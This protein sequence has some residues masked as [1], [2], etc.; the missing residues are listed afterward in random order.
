MKCSPISL[1]RSLLLIGLA[2][3]PLLA[4]AAL[5]STDPD[6]EWRRVDE[7]GRSVFHMGPV[8][9]STLENRMLARAARVTEADAAYLAFFE[10]YPEDPHRWEAALRYINS[11]EHFTIALKPAYQDSR[12][13]SDRVTDEGARAEW[14]K[15]CASLRREL[16]AADARGALP[17]DIRERFGYYRLRADFLGRRPD[18]ADPT[19][20]EKR[21]ALDRFLAEFPASSLGRDAIRQYMQTFEGQRSVADTAAEWKSFSGVGD[22]SAQEL[23]RSAL[24]FLTM[25]EKPIDFRFTAVDGREVDLARLRGKVVLLDFWATWCPSCIEELPNVAAV[26]RDYHSRGFEVVGVTLE[27][28][29]VL[30]KDSSGQAAAKMARSREKLVDFV[31][32][33]DIPWPQ[34][35]DGRDWG[36]DLVRRFAVKAVPAALLLDRS[37]RLVT[38][39]ARGEKLEREVKRLLGL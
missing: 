4:D 29:G 23:V 33:R 27:R 24:D 18:G 11:E 7:L 13:D 35:F 31:R 14:L 15:H 32:S 28:A 34:Y 12:S 20:G 8:P 22:S 30:A 5:T 37:G 38:L 10:R 16:E 17:P 2:A 9:G 3:A 19:L 26:Y 39:D 36:N 21:A 1:G 25:A 6:A